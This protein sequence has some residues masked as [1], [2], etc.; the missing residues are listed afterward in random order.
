MRRAS[1]P[2][3][4]RMGSMPV[5]DSEAG[6]KDLMAGIS[7]PWPMALMARQPQSDLGGS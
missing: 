3:G 5:A 1:P 4:P 7:P 2:R 6:I